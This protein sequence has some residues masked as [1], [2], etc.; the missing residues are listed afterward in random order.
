MFKTIQ[1]LDAYFDNREKIGIKPGLERI[2]FLLRK[3]NHPENSMKAIHIAGTNGKGSTVTYL[4]QSLLAM[5]YKVGTFTSP[6]LTNRQGMIQLNQKSISDD[7]YLK[8]ANQLFDAI[9][10]LEKR[11]DPP[12]NFELLVVISFCFF[13]E[14]A[15]IS[16]VETGMG[17]KEDATNCIRPLISIITSIGYDHMNFLGNDLAEITNHKAGIIKQKTPIIIG[18]LPEQ[19]LKVIEDAVLLKQAPLFQLGVDFKIKKID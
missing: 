9:L 6:S 2:Q 8:Y 5:D 3:V 7:D 18:K 15:D 10:E 11:E 14:Y 1:Q 17:G 19:A 12:S 16:I 4:E 13:Q